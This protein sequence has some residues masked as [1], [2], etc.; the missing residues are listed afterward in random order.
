VF[1]KPSAAANCAKC[2]N[3]TRDGV[4]RSEHPASTV[5]QWCLA[6]L[7]SIHAEAI[8]GDELSVRACRDCAD[9]VQRAHDTLGNLH[10]FDYVANEWR[11][12]YS[13]ATFAGYSS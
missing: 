2:Q 5:C 4:S 7:C 8:F 1:D 11:A 13:S 12:K 10:V 6:N 9:K 3:H